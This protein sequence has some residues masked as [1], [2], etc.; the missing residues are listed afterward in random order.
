MDDGSGVGGLGRGRHDGRSG[1]RC[2]LGDDLGV[3]VAAG[4]SRLATG[5]RSGRE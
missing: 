1:V 4:L 2:R 3:G 5:Q